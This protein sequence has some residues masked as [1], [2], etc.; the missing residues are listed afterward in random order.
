MTAVALLALSLAG[1]RPELI[2]RFV[3][4]V[5]PE[6]GVE[7]NVELT[8]IPEKTEGQAA[9][10]PLPSG[11]AAIDAD[12]GDRDAWARVDD[13]PGW[14]RAGGYFSRVDQLPALVEFGSDEERRP[15]RFRTSLE[16]D[17]RVVLRRWVYSETHG[18]PY[19]SAESAQGLDALISLV[20]EA[21]RFEVDRQFGPDVGVYPAEE[22]LRTEARAM[23]WA[24]LSVSRGSPG[25]ER[26]ETRAQRWK[27][28]LQQYGL[29]V[30]EGG[31]PDAFWD[32]Q[33]PVVLDW[34]RTNIAARL[35][36]E[37]LP[38]HPA[39]LTFWP[40]GEDWERGMSR[41]TEEVWG[42]EDRLYE[43]AEPH[44]A[45]MAGFY[46]GDDAPRVR[47]EARVEM[48]GVLMR[49]NGTPD[50]D[51]VVWV[52]RQQDLTLGELMLR[53][54]SV[55]PDREV[56]TDFGAR[57]DFDRASLL[58]LADI[59]WGRDTDGRLTSLLADAVARGHLDLLRDDDTVPPELLQLAA[60]LADLLDPEVPLPEPL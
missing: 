13:G 33:M 14:I 15:A 52:F 11:L 34:L 41:V 32:A 18:D 2:V 12:V 27:Q 6:G 8:L 57:R 35:S 59:L 30:V 49:T 43:L 51:S 37:D 1:C 4:T 50:D 54:E 38:I 46:G 53:A 40:A 20:V 36:T 29:P 56:L 44:L 3:T 16:I 60:E 9:Q 22:F 42:S 19:S 26:M 39:D 31:E 21:L 48:P 25:W 58:R 23:T 7:R 10:E 45:A 47:F 55:E 17:E 28:L 24:M 5:Y